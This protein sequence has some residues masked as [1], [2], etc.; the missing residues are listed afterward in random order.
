MGGRIYTAGYQV[1]KE[2]EP[3]VHR[4]VFVIVQV[5]YTRAL[6]KVHI[7]EEARLESSSRAQ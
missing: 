7:L 2:L 4:A 5:K 3:L 1:Q 6:T